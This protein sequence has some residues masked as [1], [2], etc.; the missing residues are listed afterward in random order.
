MLLTELK[1][2]DYK[3]LFD[4]E[5]ACM[6]HLWK[7]GYKSVKLEEAKQEVNRHINELVEMWE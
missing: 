4:L 1:K 5:M 7:M 3:S 6:L 2:H